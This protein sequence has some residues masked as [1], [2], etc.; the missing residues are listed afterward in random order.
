MSGCYWL[1]TNISLALVSIYS[2]YMNARAICFLLFLLG[3]ISCRP[4]SFSEH[5]TAAASAHDPAASVAALLD[6]YSSSP[7]IEDAVVHIYYHGPKDDMAIAGD[8][9]GWNPE[10][11]GMTQVA[12][13]SLWYW[14]DT[15]DLAGNLHYKFVSEGRD[16]F[17]DPRNPLKS[18][19]DVDNSVIQMPEYQAETET[20]F[21][22]NIPHGDIA[23]YSLYSEALGAD[24]KFKVYFPAGYNMLADDIPFVLVNDGYAYLEY[25]HMHHVLDKLI[26][27]K[28]I[29]PISAV[30]LPP[31]S[32]TAEYK[33]SLQQPFIRF[34]VDELYAWLT[35]QHNIS[36]QQRSAAVFGSSYGGTISLA[37]GAAAPDVFGKVGAFSAYV[38]ADYITQFAAAE[39]QPFELYLNHGT[40]DHLLPIEESIVAFRSVLDTKKFDYRYEEYPEAH[41]Y[42][43]WRAHLDDALLYL[44][45]E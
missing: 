4:K 14:T 39:S 43:F 11:G 37:L 2:I 27:D 13:T 24:R 8:F 40:Y 16:W 7:V 29:P 5:I 32:R 19:S 9:N 12:G 36:D 17:L 20:A 26:N 45:A 18:S 33:D 41:H 25:G 3:I 1:V 34:V 23:E 31:V 21:L 35:E 38:P 44:F 22:P 10:A 15:F 42:E 30:F 6:T 28:S